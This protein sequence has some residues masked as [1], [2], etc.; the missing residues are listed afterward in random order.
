MNDQLCT[1]ITCPNCLAH[2]IRPAT[3]K[4]LDSPGFCRFLE[5]DVALCHYKDIHDKKS[6]ILI[7]DGC[8]WF[9]FIH[10]YETWRK[11]YKKCHRLLRFINSN[12][13]S[14]PSL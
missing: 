12:V 9:D 10:G 8:G 11:W 13:D 2:A 4:E 14:R 3:D 7:C 6:V 5:E 1:A